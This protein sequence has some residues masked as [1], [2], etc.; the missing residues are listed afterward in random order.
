MDWLEI[1]QLTAQQ[2]DLLRQAAA[3]LPRLFPHADDWQTLDGALAEIQHILD[4]GAAFAAVEGERL[5]GWI[6]ALSVYDGHVWELHPLGV[7]PAFQGQGIGRRLV[8]RLEEAARAVGVSTMMLGTDDEDDRTT[9]SLVD[10]L[11]ADLWGHIA[12]LRNLDERNPHPFSF[13]E[14]LGY[15]VVGII[16]DANGPRKPDILMGKSMR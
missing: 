1:V 2:P 8:E 11:Y 14:Q 7:D 16:P 6:G 15:R 3:L 10:D 4:E 12:R 9:L 13:Y 5:L